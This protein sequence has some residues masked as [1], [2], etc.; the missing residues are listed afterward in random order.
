MLAL[1]KGQKHSP[2]L[3]AEFTQINVK[4]LMP[5]LRHNVGIVDKGRLA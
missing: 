1:L 2:P 5:G 4:K 3:Y